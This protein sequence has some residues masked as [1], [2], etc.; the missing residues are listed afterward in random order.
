MKLETSKGVFYVR[1]YYDESYL[2]TKPSHR[3]IAASLTAD[4]VAPLWG[5]AICSPRDR[6]D[7]RKGRTKALA[8]AMRKV[9]RSL[10]TEIWNALWGH[11]VKRA[12]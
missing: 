6:Y 5:T 7:H 2:N 12:S 8:R 3:V 9:D 10:R 1:F 4:G 11:G